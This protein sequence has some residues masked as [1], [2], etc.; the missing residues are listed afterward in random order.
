MKSEVLESF[1]TTMIEDNK[2]HE[3]KPAQYFSELSLKINSL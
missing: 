1:M 2:Q 3:W